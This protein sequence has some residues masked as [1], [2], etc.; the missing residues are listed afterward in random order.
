MHMSAA[1]SHVKQRCEAAESGVMERPT[2]FPGRSARSSLVLNSAAQ[3]AWRGME[4]AAAL[5]LRSLHPYAHDSCGRGRTDAW[6]G[7]EKKTMLQDFQI[8]VI[9]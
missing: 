3:E 6:R 9:L 1:G 7:R 4:K 2:C 8:L 5:E